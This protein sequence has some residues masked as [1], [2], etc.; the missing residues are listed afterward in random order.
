MTGESLTLWQLLLNVKVFKCTINKNVINHIKS[1][2][3]CRF[4]DENM[5]I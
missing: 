5:E 2:D 3:C 4:C 1:T